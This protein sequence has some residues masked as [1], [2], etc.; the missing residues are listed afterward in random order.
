MKPLILPYRGKHPRIAGDAYVAP[1]AVIIGDVVIGARANIWFGCVLRGDSNSILVGPETNIQ[2]GT[3]I[4]VN[5]APAGL[6]PAT[7]G[8]RVS[9][10]AR[11]TIGHMAL[12]HACTLED[13]SFIGMRAAVIDGAVVESGAMVA[14]GAL[15]TPNKRVKK[16]ELWA[17]SPAKFFR[18][19]TPADLAD[20]EAT[21]RHYCDL[22]DEYRQAG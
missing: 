4:H 10:G 12:I 17:G 15:V 11:V 18:A 7:P 6:D 19:L 9:I 13:G 20:F 14:A 3:V 2:D 1:G 16:G 22:A 5:E 21:A 8:Y